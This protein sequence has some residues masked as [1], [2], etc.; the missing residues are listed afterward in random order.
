MEIRPISD[1]RNKFTEIEQVVK[2]YYEKSVE[3][4]KIADAEQY[5]LSLKIKDSNLHIKD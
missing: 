2:T 5:R 1:L 4:I 3:F